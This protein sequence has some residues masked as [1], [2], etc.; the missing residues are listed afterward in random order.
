MTTAR[1]PDGFIP[2]DVE[3]ARD[4]WM[5]TYANKFSLPVMAQS[6]EILSDLERE[7]A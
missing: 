1:A 5:H 6:R 2:Y 4:L 3:N 7:R